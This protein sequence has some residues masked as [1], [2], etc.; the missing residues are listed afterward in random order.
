MDFSY[1]ISFIFF[2][3]IDLNMNNSMFLLIITDDRLIK[4]RYI[5]IFPHIL[6][7]IYTNIFTKI[8]IIYK[9][10]KS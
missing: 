10:Q 9:T 3:K 2:V 4:P 5:Y 1:H 8:K 6:E 7:L